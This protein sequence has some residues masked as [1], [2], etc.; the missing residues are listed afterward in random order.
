MGDPYVNH[1]VVLIGCISSCISVGHTI[2]YRGH[3]S[4]QSLIV[5]QAG[6]SNFVVNIKT[7]YVF[8]ADESNSKQITQILWSISSTQLTPGFNATISITYHNEISKTTSSRNK[9]LYFFRFLKRLL[10][11]NGILR[12]RR[13]VNTANEEKSFILMRLFFSGR[14]Y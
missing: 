4:L 2:P 13:I 9:K 5:S 12:Q 1:K 14:F 8:E 3:L 7:E 10:D 6:T 11:H